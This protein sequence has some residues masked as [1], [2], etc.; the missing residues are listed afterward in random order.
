MKT[1]KIL[2]FTQAAAIALMGTVAATSQANAQ[3][4]S[5]DN[6]NDEIVVTARKRSESLS[7]IPLAVTA[8][9]ET[10][11]EE[12]G[13]AGLDD[14][15]LQTTGF[16]FSNQGGQQPGRYNTQLRFRGMSTSQFSP[17]FATG[18][19]FI[20]GIYVL[21]GGTSVSLMDVQQVEVIKGPQSA[22]FGRNTFGGAVNYITRNPSLDE[23]Q[24]QIEASYTS[25]GT[26]DLS[27]ITE[28]P[29]IEDKLGISLSG[30]IYDKRGH[31][32]ATDG[33][34]LG[35]ES[36]NTFNVASYYEP[37]DHFSLKL[38]GSY[39]RDKDGA[40]AGGFVS[41]ALND[42]CTGISF[43]APSG[44]AAAPRNY[45]CGEVP[46]IDDAVTLTG[47]RVISSN[48]SIFPANT[49]VEQNIS[50][51]FNGVADNFII[52]A[53]RNNPLQAG[54]PDVG[55]VGMERETLRFS[56]AAN[57][58][59]DN[60]YEI[61]ALGGYNKQNVNWIRD[62]DL[63]DNY[64]WFSR[65]PQSVEDYTGE[66]RLT[67]P[68]E[69]RFRW[70]AGV[71]YYEQTFTASG[72]GGDAATACFAFFQTSDYSN[73]G[74]GLVFPNSF[75][76][77]DKS[78]VLGL[79]A[80][81]DFDVSDQFTLS[82]EGRYQDDTL[83]KAGTITAEGVSDDATALESKKFLPRVIAKYQPNP[84]TNLYASF[85]Q[86]VLQGDI[87]ALL[88]SADAQELA[89]YT[90]QV[91]N[92]AVETPEETLDAW[93]LG[94]KQGFMDGRGQVNIAGY[95][96]KWKGIKGRST[97]LITETCDAA[98]INEP[99]CEGVALGGLATSPN[100]RNILVPGDAD[101][102]GIEFESSLFLTEDWS[103]G[104]NVTWAKS[105]YKD[106]LF[107]FVEPISGFSNMRGNQQPRFP[108]WSGNFTSTY[109]KSLDNGW[110]MSLRGD[111]IYFGE[112]FVDESNLAFTEDYFLVNT[113]AGFAKDNIKLE[114]FVKNLFGED[115]YA[116]GAR[117]T[118]FSVPTN[119]P[120]LTAGQGVA[121]TGQDKREIGARL[122]LDF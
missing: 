40:P 28:I 19:L 67:S 70:L 12:A 80:A 118:D 93:E 88:A 90:Q 17:T 86:G 79:F 33:G 74:L 92:A 55:E 20:D 89:Q 58:K 64:N 49:V 56:A 84:D 51:L 42:S 44:E 111:V 43:T 37:T 9:S 100:P 83:E 6:Y 3:E 71:N 85:S 26:L 21:N 110:D 75:A 78:E 119:F 45:I 31:Y 104:L 120:T 101:L 103:A 41:G 16:Q 22:Y 109:N 29:I 108:E 34:R 1:R 96:N 36:T 121:V 14:I 62:F 59:L 102:W 115:A 38:R 35:N 27:A 61:D 47:Q 113:R 30:R 107:N 5:S 46:G 25:R 91:A 48:T 32:K 81:V 65:D 52:D 99:N 114:L 73:C 72:S 95:Y 69:N 53:F 18:A 66:I 24:G 94:W 4:T 63:T 68:Q 10:Q 23:F 2:L 87:N 39:S 98:K 50:G 13:F 7:D 8:F 105:E 106:Y 117:W 57:Y 122:I 97:A 15:S 116:A 112:A 77:S 76:G 54:A 82:L 60:G 11:I